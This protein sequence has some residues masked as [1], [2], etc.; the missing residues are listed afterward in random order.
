VDGIVHYRI[1]H[2][3]LSIGYMRACDT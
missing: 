1:N 3:H 2:T